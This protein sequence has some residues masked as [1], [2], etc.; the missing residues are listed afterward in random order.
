MA[1]KGLKTGRYDTNDGE[2]RRG[3]LS[4]GFAKYGL[5]EPPQPLA[6]AAPQGGFKGASKSAARIQIIGTAA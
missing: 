4:D 3:C 2:D 5:N 1:K 6:D